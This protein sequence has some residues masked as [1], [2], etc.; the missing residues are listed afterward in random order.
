MC[1]LL[2]FPG[3]RPP[4]G[5]QR[6]KLA[7]YGF[8]AVV[9]NVS[10]DSGGTAQPCLKDTSLPCGGNRCDRVRPGGRSIA[11]RLSS[12][13][14]A[15]QEIGAVHS[16]AIEPNLGFEERKARFFHPIQE[17]FVG[18]RDF[19]VLLM[20]SAVYYDQMVLPLKSDIGIINFDVPRRTGKEV[21]GADSIRV[22]RDR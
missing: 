13:C 12:R 19:L 9:P 22:V 21:K 10:Y 16:H 5:D 7:G 6:A 18:V 8:L 4:N 2:T 17:V 20:V 11:P 14:R 15:V 3:F 1:G